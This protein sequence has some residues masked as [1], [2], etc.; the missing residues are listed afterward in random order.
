VKCSILD[1]TPDAGENS[2]TP[3]SDSAME[4]RTREPSARSV[5]LIEL[6]AGHVE[7]V[8]SQLLFLKRGGYTVHLLCSEHLRGQVKGFEPVDYFAFFQPGDD[9]S[10]HWKCVLAIRR[11]LKDHRIATVVFNTGGGNHTRDICAVAPLNVKLAGIVHH[12]HKLRGSFTQSLISSRMKKAF[13]LNDY[14]LKSVPRSLRPRFRSIYLI[15][16]EPVEEEE[17]RKDRDEMWVAIPGEVDFRRRDY[18]GL[19]D[20]IRNR[21]PIDPSVRFILLGK[22]SREQEDGRALR[23]L[24]TGSGLE[25]HFVVFDDVVEQ[26]M[27]FGYLMRCDAL[28]PLIHPVTHF[29]PFYKDHQVSGTYNLAFGFAKPLLMHEAL[30]GPEDFELSAFFYGDGGLVALVNRL[31]AG[32]DQCKSRGES[33]RLSAKFS[34]DHQ[35]ERY[36]RFLER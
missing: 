21:G 17:I 35:C 5:A 4:P 19:V 23:Q 31:A 32:R 25:N 11:Y 20:E 14:L 10:G 16:R 27:F 29:F 15:F 9:F 7:C 30:R 6:G 12:T 1:G 18:K 28:L 3:D 34:F 26:R 13:V 24:I 22:C 2:K 36:L 33:I 8:Y